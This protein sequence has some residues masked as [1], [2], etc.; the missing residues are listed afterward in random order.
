MWY[1]LM[2]TLITECEIFCYIK[3]NFVKSPI[4]GSTSYDNFWNYCSFFMLLA[5][6]LVQLFA[7]ICNIFL[8]ISRFW[9]CSCCHLYFS[10]VGNTASPLSYVNNSFWFLSI[11]VVLLL[12][13]LGLRCLIYLF[14]VG[15][16]Y[17]ILWRFVSYKYVPY[18]QLEMRWK[19][20]TFMYNK[21]RFSFFLFSF[22]PFLGGCQGL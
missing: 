4:L 16:W 9:S 11:F 20:T 3:L 22:F 21:S 2:S 17:I 1:R 5:V 18:P 15:G 13:L 6:W 14:V 8:L 7:W 19:V 10:C 12:F